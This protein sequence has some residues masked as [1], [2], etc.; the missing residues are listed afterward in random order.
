MK[1]TRKKRKGGAKR[2]FKLNE[3]MKKCKTPNKDWSRGDCLGQCLRTFLL[4]D[5]MYT[6]WNSISN[7]TRK[8]PHEALS[9][10]K[11]MFES[12]GQGLQCLSMPINIK[13]RSELLEQLVSIY[14]K[15]EPG[16]SKILLIRK[17]HSLDKKEYEDG[18]KYEQMNGGSMRW[19]LL[20]FISVN[21]LDKKYRQRVYINGGTEIWHVVIISRD[22]EGNLFLIDPKHRTVSSNN[23]IYINLNSYNH[24]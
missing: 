13:T 11:Q 21:R 3:C 24:I 9:F 7:M 2:P 19:Y 22:K 14:S 6:I 1:K 8:K 17:I 20:P 23:D 16:W 10:F 4:D 12:L 5:T 15:I 18:V